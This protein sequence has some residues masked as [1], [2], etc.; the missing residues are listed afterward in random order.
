MQQ[1]GGLDAA[2]LYCETPTTH[3]HVCG[4]LLL[5]P[6]AAASS[7]FYDSIRSMLSE[8]LPTIPA[9][10]H[11]LAFTPLNVSRPFW[12]DDSDL[13]LDHHLH[14]LTL[15][16]PGDERTL[17]DLV[18]DIA[19]RQLRR[20]RPL[21]EIWVI[22]GLAKGRVAVLI[23]MHHSTID[24]V[25]GASIL[26][27]L[28]DLE[29]VA[30]PTAPASAPHKPEHAPGGLELL[31]RGL[32]TRLA[33]PLSLALLVP[34]T[35][36]HVATTLWRFGRHTD[37]GPAPAMPFT[38]PRTLFNATLTARRSVA[39]A[40]VSLADVKMVKNTFGVTVN[41]V[42]TAIMGGA[43]RSYLEGRG[44]L[45]HRP[46]LAAEPVSVHDQ[47]STQAGTTR[48]SVMFSTLATDEPDP[49]ERVRTIAAGNGRAK[50]IHQMVGADTLVR[51]SEHF[52]PNAFA[53]GAR[54]YSAL[55][56]ADHHRVVHNLILSNVPGP[57]T[58]LYM[59]GARLVGLYPLG[60]LTDGAGL[61]VTV[62]SQ[63]ER[64][65]FGIITCPDLVP[66]VWDLADA[67]P[68]ALRQ[69]VEAAV[70]AQTPEYF[71]PGPTAGRR[72]TVTPAGHEL[73]VE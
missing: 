40:D 21:W 65:G 3:L 55:H 14:R 71:D 63:G 11:R 16:P 48:L 45:P 17:A 49:A 44:E 35:T 1:L 6:S 25:T 68:G 26:G 67:I 22:E 42:V 19:S 72:D 36:C 9:V 50:E 20:D 70:E 8:R 41:D 57:P 62:L 24:G 66:E 23:K 4:L 5:E 53:L 13:D 47:T 61:N 10:H 56:V 60:P 32:A 69:L 29:P 28:L 37:G 7:S 15:R 2:F 12:V 38:A 27:H 34:T 51:W 59:A 58:P 31:A 46:L 30:R 33:A 54:L 73:E 64:V 52:W 18:G 39:F 43:L